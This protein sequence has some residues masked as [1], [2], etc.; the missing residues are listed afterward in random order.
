MFIKETEDELLA[1]RSKLKNKEDVAEGLA[2]EIVKSNRAIVDDLVHLIVKNLDL[3]NKPTILYFMASL[4]KEILNKM[5]KPI[6]LA[7]FF[8]ARFDKSG[9]EE[10][11]TDSLWNL[12]TL[13]GNHS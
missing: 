3:N 10:I 13:M 8:I 1:K 4:A 12:L 6:M 2:F 11:Q 9:D 5:D 7:D